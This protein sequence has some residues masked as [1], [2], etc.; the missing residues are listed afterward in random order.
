M[1]IPSITFI[2]KSRVLT[3][4]GHLKNDWEQSLLQPQMIE[5]WLNSMLEHVHTIKALNIRLA[6]GQFLAAGVVKADLGFFFCFGFRNC[7]SGHC[8]W[9]GKVN[10]GFL[11]VFEPRSCSQTTFTN[12]WTF[13]NPSSPPC[14][15]LYLIKVTRFI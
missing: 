11:K 14:W 1:F 4:G 8:L 12:F 10:N 3:Y 2:R 9:K 7:I 5:L 15:Q 6:T 13:F